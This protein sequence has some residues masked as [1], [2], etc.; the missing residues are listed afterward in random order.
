MKNAGFRLQAGLSGAINYV[1]IIRKCL[2]LPD[3]ACEGGGLVRQP[4]C[5]N[6][7]WQAHMRPSV[8]VEQQHKWPTKANKY[9]FLIFSGLPG[10]ILINIPTCL[11]WIGFSQ[12]SKSL[13]M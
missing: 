12:L 10:S 2:D 9:N 11:P 3:D 1:V 7:E 4:C 6:E 5:E 13:K 8:S